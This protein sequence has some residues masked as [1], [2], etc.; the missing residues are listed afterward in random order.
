MNTLLART[1][2]VLALVPATLAAPEAAAQSTLRAGDSVRVTWYGRSAVYQVVRVAPDTLVVSRSGT[3]MDL[4]MAGIQR[5]AVPARRTRLG[6][7]GHD[8][9]VGGLIGAAAG[10]VLGFA[11]GNP[12]PECWMMCYS[13]TE[14]ALMAGTALGVLG[15]GAGALT[16]AIRS[17]GL[18]WRPIPLSGLQLGMAPTGAGVRLAA[19]W[20]R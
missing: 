1:I 16:G 13:A 15:A 11:G 17:P 2:S 3:I 18:T 14:T 10:T 12:S 8:A 20:R 5:I 4:P 6:Q 19:T 9:L 7:V